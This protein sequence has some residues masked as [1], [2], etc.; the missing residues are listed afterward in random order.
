MNKQEE[1]REKAEVIQEAEIQLI[2]DL[3]EDKLLVLTKAFNTYIKRYL[4]STE[5]S[6]LK[7]AILD[8]L[9]ELL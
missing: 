4:L 2:R 1:L 5:R 3:L 8:D 6:I 9:K 7:Q